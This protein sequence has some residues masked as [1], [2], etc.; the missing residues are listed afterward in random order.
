MDE[1]PSNSHKSREIREEVT[2]PAVEKIISGKV[3]R[4]KKTLSRR[5]REL[6][7]GDD[8]MGVFE[9]VAADVIVPAIRD[10]ILD[11]VTQGME[12][13]VYG[14][15][16]GPRRSSQ[17]SSSF[18]GTSQTPY[19]RYSSSQ[20][21]EEP[22]RQPRRTTRQSSGFSDIIFETR[23]DADRILGQLE[24][25]IEKY[26]QTSVKDLYELCGEQFHYVDEKHGWTDLRGASIS[27]IHGGGY[28]LNMPPTEE[29][30]A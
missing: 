2:R 7:F 20:R 28:Y 19:H 5:A 21:R 22:T 18:G 4:R 29:L 26:G 14:E 6:F 10:L 17:R 13:A 1:F 27:R 24:D 8:T 12:R 11:A 16:R 25:F 3:T 30:E 15:S 9:Y 23:I